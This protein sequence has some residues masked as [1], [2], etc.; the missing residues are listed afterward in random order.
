MVR[1]NPRGFSSLLVAPVGV[2]RGVTAPGLGAFWPPLQRSTERRRGVYGTQGPVR[3][4][5]L[6]SG[7][8]RE[9][10]EN[11]DAALTLGVMGRSGERS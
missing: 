10:A 6:G 11:T 9:L 1:A 8:R 3:H 5:A 4:S 7:R 2:D